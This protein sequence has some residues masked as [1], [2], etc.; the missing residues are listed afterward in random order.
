MGW[1]F[2]RS[3]KIMPGVH[4]NIS[5]RGVSSLSLGGRGATLNLG[6][7]GVRQ[8]LGIPGTGLSLTTRSKRA[9]SH[10]SHAVVA[11]ITKPSVPKLELNRFGI[12]PQSVSSSRTVLKVAVLLIGGAIAVLSTIL[13]EHSGWLALVVLAIGFVLP[14]RKT[15]EAEEDRRCQGRAHVELDRRLREFRYHSDKATN[16]A[17][18]GQTLLAVQQRLALSDEEIGRHEA[19]ALRGLITLAEYEATVSANGDRLP[20]IPGHEQVVTTETC[21]FVSPATYDKRGDNDPTGSLYLSSDQ[22]IFVA[23]EGVT[24]APWTKVMSVDCEDR[25]LR[26]QRRD[27]QTPYLFDLPCV[28][29]ALKAHFIGNRILPRLMHSAARTDVS[30]DAASQSQA[31]KAMDE[32]TPTVGAAAASPGRRIDLG[33]GHGFTL[34]IVGESYRQTALRALAGDRRRLGEEVLFVAVLSPEHE[35]DYDTN[36]IRVDVE[37]GSQIGYLSRKDAVAYRD[38][39]AAVATQGA[40]AISRAQLIGGTPDKPSIGAMLDL[41]DP[42]ELLKTLS[43]V[44]PF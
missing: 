15:L 4:L 10:S 16:T 38:V 21:Y 27:R 19:A 37:G 42:S 34:G 24:A 33:T 2:R 18:S 36:A 23:P 26:V 7:R 25:V 43:N 22:L 35:N 3:L 13:P 9:V 31:A 12:T 29:D 30:E 8:T 41:E 17:T 14:S 40:V 28:G 20:A 39:L 44:Q 5:K 6:K 11:Q 32:S 1:R